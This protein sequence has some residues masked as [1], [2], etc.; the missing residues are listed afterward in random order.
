M[1]IFF[2]KYKNMLISWAIIHL[3]MLIKNNKSVGLKR[4]YYAK[5]P[6]K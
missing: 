6:T 4:V 1:Y 2:V 3:P 5:P